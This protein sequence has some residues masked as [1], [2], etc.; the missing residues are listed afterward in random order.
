[1]RLSFV[2]AAAANGV[3]GANNKLPWHLPDDLKYFK[4]LTLGK[5]ILMGRKTYESI[6]RPLPGRTN[7]VM[8]RQ[9]DLTIPGCVVVNTV[10]EAKVAAG[11]AAEL[12]V[13]GGAEL[14]VQTLSSADVIHMT[15]VHADVPGD[16]KFPALSA[17]EWRERL[18]ATHAA[19]ERHAYAFSFIDFER[20]APSA[21][22]DPTG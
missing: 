5:P 19:D 17:H 1:M 16:V 11:D 12:A 7:I 21:Q 14:F 8:T 9:K 22:R 6:G 2:V 4:A 20:I 15:R 13:I 3:I 18:I 10:E